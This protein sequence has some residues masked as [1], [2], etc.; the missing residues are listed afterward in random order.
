M[1]RRFSF[2]LDPVLVHRQRLEDAQQRIFAAAQQRVVDAERARD[3]FIARRD[4]MRARLRDGHAAMDAEELRATYAH[5]DFLDRA[6]IAQQAAI[7]EARAV[8]SIERAALLEKTRDTKVLET[9]KQHRRE[10]HDADAAAAEQREI[11]E[12]NSRRF[13]RAS[14]T[15]ETSA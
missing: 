3:D 13:D 5:C 10:A 1:A 4:D 8:A 2:Q 6:I 15:W 7:A 11:D 12:T 9:L 14:V